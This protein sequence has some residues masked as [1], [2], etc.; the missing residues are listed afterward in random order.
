MPI[1]IKDLP[2]DSQLV[3]TVY[4][5]CYTKELERAVG[6]TTLNL[7]TSNNTLR[8]GKQ[9]LY[10]W[11][12]VEGDGQSNT[13]TP[14]KQRQKDEMDRLEKLVKKQE[15]GDIPR[16]DW[17]D[18]LAFREIEKTHAKL[19]ANSEKLFLYIDL[20]TFDFPLVFSENEATLPVQPSNTP[21]PLDFCIHVWDM[22]PYRD[23]PVEVKH[24]RLV[25]S[26]RSGPLD[27]ELKPNA[28]HRDQLNQILKFPPTQVLRE[29]EKDIIWKFRYFLTKDK[30]ALTKFVKCVMWSDGWESKQAVELLEAWVDIEVEDALELLGSNFEDPNVRAYAVRQLK[31]A[32]DSDL[33]LYLLQLVQALKF[34][35]NESKTSSNITS[36][37]AEFLIMRSLKNPVLGSRFHWYL[38]VECEDKTHGRMYAKIAFQYM[39][40]MMEIPGGQERREML[41]RQGEFVESILNIMK[42]MRAK[43]D[44]RTKKIDKFRS[45]LAD[46]K[47]P[48]HS[49]APLPLPLDPEVE[50][51]GAVPEKCTIFKSNLLPLK[52]TFKC[53]PKPDSPLTS[54]SEYNLMFKLGDDLRQDQLVIQIITLMDNLLRKENLDLKLTPYSVLAT[55]T[56]HGMIQFI[57]S[58]SLAAILSEHNGSLLDYLRIHNPNPDG[59]YGVEPSVMDTYLKSCAGYCVITYLLGVGDR[60]L[61]NLLL[62]PDGHLFHIDFGYILGRDPKPFPP[63]MKLCKE[64]IEAMGGAQSPHHLK[65]KSYCFVTFNSLRKSANL[66]L[67]LLSLMVD[68]NIPDI[69]IEPDKAVMKV[70]E[71]FCLEL[72]DEEAS[73]FFQTLINDS[74]S[75]LFPQV[76]ETIHKWAQYWRK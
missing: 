49:F 76:I 27:K 19:S 3:I 54:P 23:N 32:N 73:Q 59:P 33:L 57:P 75:A 72:T 13:S 43:K 38:M 41:R 11:P 63:P 37:L 67:N 26:H 45:T 16:I 8:K 71:K 31:K 61:D 6:G 2:L 28:G 42:K 51:T 60:H 21:G 58:Q 48:L 44:V 7:F 9:K 5:S 20:P 14:S 46:P 62:T 18:K 24:R 68:A 25:R 52:M 50:I 29:E 69:A 15:S 39:S 53:A 66:I 30:K 40:A 47:N 74:V 65:F 17:L 12:G 55:G 34:D 36:S 4:E 35:K 1:L 56:E 64:M 22:E 10:L 70:Q